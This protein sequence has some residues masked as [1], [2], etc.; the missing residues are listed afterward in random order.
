MKL[1]RHAGELRA[2]LRALTAANGSLL[3][4]AGSMLGTAAV[5][6]LLGA[7]FWWLAAHSFNQQAVGLASAAVAAMTLLG[8]LATLGL[9]T[10]LLG[11]LPRSQ[12]GH[13]SL[14]NAALAVT[15]STGAVLGLCFAL[16]A[17]LVSSNFQPISSTWLSTISFA[18]GVGLTALALV[19]DQALIGL[20]RGG[21]QLSRNAVF[22]LIKLLALIP[23]AALVA[24]AGAPWIYSAWVLGIVFSLVVLIRLYLHRAG[25]PLRPNFAVLG[26]MRSSAMAHHAFNLALEAAGLALPILV[27]GLISASANASFYIAW[28]IVAHVVMVPASLGTVLYPIGSNDPARLLEGLRVTIRISFAVGLAANL[29]LLPAAFPLLQIFGSAYAQQGTLPLHIMALAVFPLT[30]KALYVAIHRVERR[31]GKALPIVWGGTLLELGAA[32]VGGVLGGLT[33]VALGWL[34]A[35]CIEGLVMGAGV[36]RTILKPLQGQQNATMTEAELAVLT[37]LDAA[38]AADRR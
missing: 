37:G 33:G 6:S 7:V 23:I 18:L 29:I 2:E 4:N 13:R 9:G 22:A 36:L 20:L 27:V 21:L 11:E 12:E 38:S 32:A 30:F 15:A 31:L 10:L 19:L 3:T 25:E 16:I 1:P 34:I 5:T 28:M 17:P 24:Q 8:F 26:A 35:V 14:I